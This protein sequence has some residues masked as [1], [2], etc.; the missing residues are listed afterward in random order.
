M[1]DIKR[2]AGVVEFV[3]NGKVTKVVGNVSCNL[4][5]PTKEGLKG[6][7]GVH[8][9][10]EDSVIPFIEGEGRIVH[11]MSIK[12]FLETTDATVTVKFATGH[13]YMISDAWY[14]G[15]G[16]FSSEEAVLPFKFAGMHGEE[17]L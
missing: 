14:E 8:G 16:T 9:Y 10:K 1:A 2:I 6:P 11:G 17:I 15:E 3:V 4:G 5:I 12:D 7:D 13:I